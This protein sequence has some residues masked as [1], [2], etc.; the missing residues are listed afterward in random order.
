MEVLRK[1]KPIKET[2][3]ITTERENMIIKFK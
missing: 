3:E 1:E 2:K